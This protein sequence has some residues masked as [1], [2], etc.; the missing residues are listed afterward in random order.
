MKT[1]LHNSIIEQLLL[2]NAITRKDLVKLFNIR[3]A[4]LYSAIDA[5]KSSGLLHEPER[6]G[7]RTGRKASSLKFNSKHA[8]FIGIDLRPRKIFGSI[9]D[10]SG[11]ITTTLYSEFDPTGSS[12]QLVAA[13]LA[14]I[15]ELI[16]K[17]N[18]D[19]EKLQGLALADPG[20]VDRHNL[21]S[22]I[23]VTIDNWRNVPT[24]Q[25]IAKHTGISNIIIESG[26]NAG[27]FMEYSMIKPHLPE[28][29]FNLAIGDGVGSGLIKN[30]QLF[31]GATNSRMEIGHLI[32]NPGGTLCQCGNRGC[33]ETVISTPTIEKKIETLIEHRVNSTLTSGNFSIEKFIDAVKCNDK[34]ALSIAAEL[35][36]NIAIALQAVV[37]LINPEIIIIS[38]KLTGLGDMMLNNIRQYL[39][40]NC[41]PAAISQI[42]IKLSSLDQFATSQGAALLAREK[43][44]LG[45]V[46]K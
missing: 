31:F 21:V 14:F 6:V 20:L 10:L 19:R 29:L 12:E 41:Q 26:A 27:T 46:N 42:K 40:L 1:N 44:L 30:G 36:A 15:D 45:A 39:E 28:S 3:P 32:I 13:L 16:I 34:G 25:I 38:G 11:N 22:V 4:S 5:L 35:C 17:S 24:G 9:I 23:A 2:N 7:K 33:L 8:Y 37:A 18:L 43:Y